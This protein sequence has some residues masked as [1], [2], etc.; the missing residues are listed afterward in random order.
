MEVLGEFAL[1]AD[2]GEHDGGNQEEHGQ[3]GGCASGVVSDEPPGGAPQHA[4][5]VCR[6]RAWADG[7]PR[8]AG[9]GW[10]EEAVDHAQ[11][12]EGDGGQS[13]QHVPLE[14]GR[15]LIDDQGEDDSQGQEDGEGPVEE[16]GG[17]VPDEDFFHGVG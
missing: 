1:G 11:G 15:V 10:P 8:E 2:A 5:H 4:D 9:V 13:A 7:E 3:G 14:G 17:K 12:Q 6:D 16:A